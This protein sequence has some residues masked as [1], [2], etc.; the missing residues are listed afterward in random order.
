MKSGFDLSMDLFK[1]RERG[2]LTYEHDYSGAGGLP[3]LT[4]RWFDCLHHLKIVRLQFALNRLHSFEVSLTRFFIQNCKALEVL[5][6]DDKKQI[7]SSHIHHMVA[8][9]RDSKH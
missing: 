6:V 4:D 8:R 2:G 9:W 1:Q 5:Q 7:F 3:G